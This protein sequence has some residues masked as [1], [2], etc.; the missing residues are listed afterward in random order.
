MTVDILG[1]M[2]DNKMHNDIQAN[3]IGSR[4]S[5]GRDILSDHGLNGTIDSH[6]DLQFKTCQEPIAVCGIALRLPGG[7]RNSESFWD[8]LINGKD[9]R[10]PIPSTR[11]NAEGFRDK[12]SE[13]EAIKPQSGYF[14][15]EDLSQLDTSFF[16]MTK[17][18]LEMMDPQ[19]RQV[20]EVAKECFENA[21]EV[22]YRGRLVGCYV[23]T[24]GEDWLQ[25]SAKDSQHSGGARMTGQADIMIANRVS[26]EL[27]LLGPR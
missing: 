13:K 12:M 23:G 8:V 27:G 24:F 21:G 16:S 6:N 19:Q 3:G 1:T 17:R 4:I 7:I 5:H 14:L 20:L 15:E 25:M 18:E 11:Y 10:G 2:L 22:D 9:T 26:Y